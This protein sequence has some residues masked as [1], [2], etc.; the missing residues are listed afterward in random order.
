M[1][2]DMILET[3]EI[4]RR[5]SF[6]GLCIYRGQVNFPAHEYRKGLICV[7]FETE[8]GYACMHLYLVLHPKKSSA[9][10]PTT[11]GY[12]SDEE[13]SRLHHFA[14]F[15]RYRQKLE[16]FWM[17]MRNA[18]KSRDEVEE[19]IRSMAEEGWED[20]THRF[21]DNVK[22]EILFDEKD[23]P[24]VFEEFRMDVRRICSRPHTQ[25]EREIAKSMVSQVRLH[26]EK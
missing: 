16:D 7:T 17:G 15:I 4:C 23:L 5:Q 1:I 9:Y 11:E 3:V 6:Y 10:D 2:E 14:E 18:G 25:L 21:V 24:R 19:K 13:E 12:I 20:F 26:A 22:G 8:F